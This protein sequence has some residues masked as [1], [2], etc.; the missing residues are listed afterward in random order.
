VTSQ[1]VFAVALAL[2]VAQ[3]VYELRLSRRHERRLFAR[4]AVEHAPRH[5]RA[6]AALHGSW[7]VAMSVEV[8]VFDAAFHPRVAFVALAV[9]IAGQALRY[10]AIR[11]LGERWTVRV[12]TLPGQEPVRAGIYRHVRHP[13]YAGVV[14]EIAAVPLLH[15][16]F[17]TSVSYSLANAVVLWVRIR[18]EERALSACGNYAGLLRRPRFLPDLRQPDR[19]PRAP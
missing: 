16:A 7:F 8:F 13:N 15:G 11:T 6:M 9:T 5:F 17:F 4:G 18:A 1:H 14:L 2:L 19:E 10:A 12:I 3:R